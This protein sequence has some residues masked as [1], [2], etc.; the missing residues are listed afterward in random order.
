[1]KRI[2]FVA[3]CLSFVACSKGASSQAAAACAV[4]QTNRCS[5]GGTT[6]GLQ[7]CLPS[8]IAYGACACSDACANGADCVAV[9]D[10]TGMDM[11]Q[12]GDIV[13]DAGLALPDSADLDGG[14]T[15]V[16]MVADPPVQVFDGG[17]VPTQVPAPGVPVKRGTQ[18]QLSVTLPPNQESLGLPNSHF[19]VGALNQDTDISAQAYYDTIDPGPFPK[20]ATLD[21]WKQANHFFDN[22]EPVIQANAIYVSHADLGFGRHMHVRV[23]KD[24]SVA[25]YV[26]NYL[27]GGDAVLGSNYFA[28]VTMEWS[29]G[30]NGKLTDPFFTQFYVYNKKGDRIINPKLDDHGPKNNPSVC[31]SCHGSNNTDFTY[32]TNGGNI[33]AR[34]VP[35]DVDNLQF[36]PGAD[37]ASQEASLKALNEAVFSTWDPNDPLYAGVER[38]PVMDMI[39]AFYGGPGHPSPTFIS[40][41]VLPG[42]D[43]SQQGHDLYSKVFGK[44]CVGCHAQREPFRNFSTIT[45]FINEKPLVATRVFEQGVMPLSEKGSRNFWTSYPSQPKILAAFLGVPFKSPGNPVAHITVSHPGNFLTSGV[46]VT[47][48]GQTSQY[49]STYTW[50]QTGG[51]TVPLSSA[52]QDNSIMTF[53]A[54]ANGATLTFQLVVSLAG[55]DSA[56]D[57]ATVSVQGAP[58]PPQNVVAT[59]GNRS[60]TL[61]WLTVSNGGDVIQHSTI[62]TQPGGAVA[63]ITGAGTTA[64]ITGLTKGIT[65]TFTIVSTNEID[66]SPASAPSNAV[67][68]FTNPD[69]PGA[70]S[71]VRGNGQATLSWSLP[72]DTGGV[73]IVAYDITSTPSLGAPIHVAANGSG[74]Q[75]TTV[76]GLTNGTSYV[77]SVVAD[78][79]A[80]STPTALP[81]VVPDVQPGSPTGVSAQQTGSTSA[82]VSWTAPA[83]N[84]GTAVTGYR[85]TATDVATSASLT[86]I[87]VPASPTAAT[88]TGLTANHT[89]T[90]AVEALNGAGAGNNS[91]SSAAVFMAA[92]VGAPSAPNTVA[93]A[94]DGSQLPGEAAIVTW[95]AP[96]NVGNSPIS[97]YEI[98]ATPA[99]GGVTPSPVFVSGSTFSMRFGT[100]AGTTGAAILTGGV[101]YTFNV[102]AVNTQGTGPGAASGAVAIQGRPS[103]PALGTLTAFAGAVGGSGSITANWSA[104]ANNG[105]SA[106]TNYTASFSGTN[107]SAGTALAVNSGA[108]PTRCTTYSV[109]VTASNIWGSTTSASTNHVNAVTPGPVSA[110]LSSPNPGLLNLSWGAVA[111]TGCNVTYSVSSSPTTVFPATTTGT[112]FSNASAPSCGY[113]TTGGGGSSSTHC[114]R[115]WTASV[116]ASNALGAGGIGGTGSIR[117]LVSYANDGINAIWTGNPRIN[118]VGCHTT[119]SG[120][121]MLLNNASA[122][123]KANITAS[124]STA[125]ASTSEIVQCPQENCNSTHAC[126]TMNSGFGA[127]NPF[128]QGGSA[129][130][131]VLTAWINDGRRD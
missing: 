24:K 57:V 118:C 13:T 48:S 84:G 71:T 81:A 65:Y 28:T 37:R 73:P 59:A 12:V 103:A 119:G 63:Q 42:W 72:A 129:E 83:P 76:T 46:V 3:A 49:G 96:D 38:P 87:D 112:S 45:K 123:N 22:D 107:V 70:V 43:V 126:P 127:G 18:M 62:T 117:P 16:E 115:T 9:P 108:L 131:T 91:A 97:N 47:M 53:P 34:F 86:P 120:F 66:D 89:Y 55:K 21:D 15:F 67:T 88:V 33:G 5:C 36:P 105:G 125:S 116:Q 54:P 78:N 17:V 74:T 20:R 31:L 80:V 121:A 90:F 61:N 92:T 23:N 2:L 11:D 58:A 27:T 128:L 40:D 19:L 14:F 110:S 100:A 98:T 26:D 102:S 56:P 4:N 82:T 32:Q 93:A 79:G 99:A 104:P 75:T 50:T 109:S 69:P 1:M 114:G 94:F 64:T 44:S 113:T 30:P 101:S 8:R 122:T 35:F 51:P 95:A 130:I 124:F 10:L 6:E 77:F 106:I 25:F 60:A 29:P 85:I 111:E 39:D 52:A 68:V 7:I 41:T